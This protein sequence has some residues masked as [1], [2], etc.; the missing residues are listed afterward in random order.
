[1]Y[2]SVADR[3][4]FAFFKKIV[5]ILLLVILLGF[6]LGLFYLGDRYH[7]AI[8]S[9]LGGV[10][11]LFGLFIM[12][13]TL[14]EVFARMEEEGTFLFGA[15]IAHTFYCYAMKLSFVPLIGPS[16]ERLVFRKK[17]KNPFV[18]GNENDK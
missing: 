15:A 10:F 1:M 2:N 5:G 11:F 17:E 14:P 9:V 6:C 12:I 4:R 18:V 3:L 7:L 16:I 8:L 13:F